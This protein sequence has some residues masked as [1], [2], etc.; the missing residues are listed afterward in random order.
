ML[1]LLILQK[2]IALYA[3]SKANSE[4]FCFDI[5]GT[6][7]Q[8]SRGRLGYDFAIRTS[9]T[10]A[11][12][13]DFNEEMT[14][15]WEAFGNAYFGENYGSTDLDALETVRDVILRL[16]YHWYSFMLLARGTAVTDL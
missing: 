10:P 11:R 15:A 7:I 13:S 1:S 9:C 16:T 2:E 6:W 3:A 14:S 12:W 4:F 5:D 8:C